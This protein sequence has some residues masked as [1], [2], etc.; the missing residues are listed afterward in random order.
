MPKQ[1]EKKAQSRSSSPKAAGHWET[2]D[3][4]TMFPRIW[5]PDVPTKPKKA[6]K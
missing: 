2:T 1:P 3:T 5:V 6:K 4:G